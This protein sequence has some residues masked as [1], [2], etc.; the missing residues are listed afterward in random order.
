MLKKNL[1]TPQE[2]HTVGDRLDEPGPADTVGPDSILDEGA[3]FAF[4]PDRVG[5][6]GKDDTQN[7]E[8]LEGRRPDEKNLGLKKE[9]EA[10]HER[11]RRTAGDPPPIITGAAAFNHKGPPKKI[12]P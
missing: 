11:H 6:H 2:L 1:F 4:R 7:D 10:R 12:F 5:N 8:G 3:D 9:I